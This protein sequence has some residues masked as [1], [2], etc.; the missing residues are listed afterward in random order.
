MGNFTQNLIFNFKITLVFQMA[1]KQIGE[2]ANGQIIIKNI[3]LLSF[4]S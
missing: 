1:K 2:N 3:S 4:Y